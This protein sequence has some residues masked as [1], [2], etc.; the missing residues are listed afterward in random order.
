MA[1]AGRELEDG[2]VV[3]PEGGPLMPAPGRLAQRSLP[4]V[5]LVDARG[6]PVSDCTVELRVPGQRREDSV[7]AGA[8]SCAAVQLGEVEPGDYLLMAE[9]PGFR[10]SERPVHLGA[11]RSPLKLV[12]LDGVALS[13]HVVDSAGRPVPEVSVVVSPTNAVA[14]S[15]GAGA[16][17]L[18]VP[19]PGVYS[20]EA[21]HSDWGGAVQAVVVPAADVMLRLLPRSVLELR[22]LSGGRPVEGARADLFDGRDSGPGGAYE[23]DR[24]T[25][26]NGAV[27]MQGFPPGTYTLGVLRPGALGP[28]HQEV[29]L[30]ERATTAVTVT[31]PSLPSGTIEGEVVDA[32]GKPVEGASVQTQPHEVAPVQSDTTGHFRLLGVPDGVDYQVAAD[33]EKAKSATHHAYAGDKGL[34]LSLSRARRYRGRVVDGAHRPVPAFRL[35]DVKVE[36][37]DGRFALALP[38][39]EGIVT[40]T[41][42]APNL[43]IATFV[44]PAEVEEVGDVVLHSAPAVHG[45]VREASGVPA[46]GALVVCEGCRGEAEGERRL[47]ALTDAEG[48]F[49]LHVTAAYGVLVRL[50]A[51]KDGRLGWAEAGRADEKAL[52]TLAAP[53]PVRGRVLHSNGEAAAGVAVV[54]FEPLLEPLLL[55]SGQDGGFS[56]EVPPG[57]YRVTLTPDTSRPRRT[58]TVQVPTDGPLQLVGGA[59]P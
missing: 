7:E 11:G 54:F 12:L 47:T 58:W 37:E 20:L 23:A 14:R 39:R 26:A 9:A 51:M 16:F 6:V 15:D 49:T 22:V 59:P 50:L 4:M 18:S 27:R 13:G 3:S 48:R 24:A 25:D 30:R 36:A 29:V 40:F 56:G 5:A 17:R 52:L 31:L 28:S 57:L 35:G 19:G 8:D 10:R 42:E 34:R 1:R 45:V 41:I 2:T 33:F 53:A 46:A 44:R 55:V 21:H 43:A 38:A 32:A